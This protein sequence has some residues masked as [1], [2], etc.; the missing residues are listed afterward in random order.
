MPSH[1]KGH[2]GH[3]GQDH[4][5]SS[6]LLVGVLCALCGGLRSSSAA[7][8]TAALPGGLAAQVVNDLEPKTMVRITDGLER[9]IVARAIDLDGDGAPEWL[10]AVVHPLWCGRRGGYCPLAVYRQTSGAFGRLFPARGDDTAAPT[11]LGVAGLAGVHV[12]PTRSAGFLDIAWHFESGEEDPAG[13]YDV[14]LTYD[15]TAYRAKV[16]R[17]R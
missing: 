17:R 15:G 3:P 9:A 1:Y 10:V 13:P 16:E 14:V 7:Q 11:P 12:G 4:A 2:A 8:T 6:L 5:I